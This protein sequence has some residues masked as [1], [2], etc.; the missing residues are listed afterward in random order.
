MKHTIKVLFI[1][2]FVQ[3][4]QAQNI[5]LFQQF[6]GRYDYLSFGN[7]LNVQENGGGDPCIIQTESSAD[8]AL[9]ADQTIIA[10]YLYWAGS[11]DPG[12]LEV[13]LN[14]VDVTAS[15]DFAL[16][17][18]SNE[19]DYT[20]FAAFA[21]VTD[22]LTDQGNGTYTLSELDLTSNIEFYC[23]GNST[24]FGGWAVTVIYEDPD[25]TL[26]NV[27]LFDG[28]ES[29]SSSNNNLTITLLNLNVIDDVGA[30]IG[31]LAWEGDAALA[32]NETLSIN[33]NLISNPPL[34]PADNAFNSTNSFT[35]STDL[36]NM[37]IDFYDIENNIMPGDTEVVIDL[38][39]SQDF[40]MINNIITVLNTQIPDATITIDQTTVGENCGD[41]E[42]PVEYTV[43]NLN[44][45]DVLQANAPIAF[46][47]NNTLVG[48]SAT[49]NPI[50]IGGQESGMIT[51]TIPPNIPAD[52]TLRA[53]VDD[54][55]NGN[56]IVDESDETNN[57]FTVDLHILIFPTLNTQNL[58]IC[59]AVGV[60]I[61]DLT[62]AVSTNASNDLVTFH[63]TQMNAENGVNEILNP[64]NFTS[65]AIFQTIYVRVDNGDCVTIGSFTI[66]VEICPLPDATIEITEMLF[67]CRQRLLDI[68][69]RVSNID[70]TNILPANTS[71]AFYI[72]SQLVATS[73]TQ[74]DI[75]IGGFE[76]GVITIDVDSAVPNTFMLELRVDDDGT[77]VGSV[78][79]LDETNNIWTQ[80]IS[81]NTIPDIVPLPDL[82]AC[83][84][85]FNLATF[86]LTAQDELVTQNTQGTVTYYTTLEDAAEQQNPIEDPEQ[87]TNTTDPQT[88]F[89]R[90]EN[91]VCFTI[92]S[93]IIRTE[94]CPPFIP[95]G[96]SPNNDS[97]N[98]VFEI[99]NILNV[100]EDFRLQIY[101]R[102]GSLIYEGGNEE[103][104]W[105]GIPNKGLL[106]QK[107]LVPVGTYFYVLHLNDSKYKEP[108]TGF[109]YI[110][111]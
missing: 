45:T 7:T 3:L 65:T 57:D 70:A 78:E 35:G 76:D 30:K 68:P 63:F 64:E 55:G 62:S 27:S 84:E 102:Y 11:L 110:N 89:V 73:Q 61:F 21:D 51:L 75:P 108:F 82:V 14:G 101:N 28:L 91:E 8:F 19:V 85:G 103:G 4:G 44:S 92:G 67:P 99:S 10:A 71:I 5:E 26:R 88:I 96:F 106:Y 79:E 58:S 47:A 69:Y 33:G 104:F 53:V 29:V 95:Q 48:Q 15:R 17:F 6:N 23:N 13:V 25:F 32:N 34:N 16:T 54:L 56:G 59:N 40:V 87:Y 98:D 2:L 12:D 49:V 37:D 20:Y 46:Y 107:K 9:E 22:I 52:F 43:F 81:F 24:N 105:D 86:N 60:E 109:V 42:I 74:N 50:P 18:T 100:F 31:F 38:T 90:L 77:G 72:A 80:T 66:E 111:Y 93:F 94:N 36:Y 1:I 83:N 41:N 97:I 39:S